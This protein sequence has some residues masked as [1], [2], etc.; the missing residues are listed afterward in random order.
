MV[1]EKAV[2]QAEENYRI[3][4]ERYK[5]QVATST[6]VLDALTLLDRAQVNYYTA[7]SDFNI[8]RA[9]LQK[10]TGRR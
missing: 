8:A 5:E 6:E 7:L 10:A 9:R 2:G 1:A 3:N 4:Q